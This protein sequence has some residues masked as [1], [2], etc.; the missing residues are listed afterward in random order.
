MA[1]FKLLALGY[2]IADIATE[3]S[4]NV[5]T[6]STY[7]SRILEKMHMKS[8]AELTLYAAEFRII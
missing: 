1:V 8:N 5:S 2:S 6:V 3:L 7:R 4:L